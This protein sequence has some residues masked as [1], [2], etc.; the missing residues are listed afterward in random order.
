MDA[1]DSKASVVIKFHKIVNETSS[2]SSPSHPATDRSHRHCF[3]NEATEQC[4][5]TANP[6]ILLHVLSSYELDPKDLAALEASLYNC[7][8][9]FV[10]EF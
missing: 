2:H 5:L 3:G 1:T 10:F 6:S 7:D 4:P 8:M 9:F